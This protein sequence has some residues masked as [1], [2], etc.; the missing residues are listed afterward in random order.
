MYVDDSNE[1]QQ[2]IDRFF[3]SADDMLIIHSLL[4]DHCA[5]RTSS[6]SPATPSIYS[7]LLQ[8][9]HHLSSIVNQIQ[10]DTLLLVFG[11]HG[12]SRFGNHGGATKDEITTGLC[13]YCS[14][15]HFS[16]HRDRFI[17]VT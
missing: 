14:F 7:S 6:S 11:D 15:P 2:E 9:N 17:F 1:I 10:N 4:L 13:V 3:Q 5:H 16:L 12:L 8:L